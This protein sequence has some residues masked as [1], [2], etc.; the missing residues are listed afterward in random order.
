MK[1]KKII[2][3][4]LVMLMLIPGTSAV[5]AADPPDLIITDMRLSKEDFRVGDVVSVHID[6]KNIGGTIMDLGYVAVEAYDGKT[7]VGWESLGDAYTWSR[8][9]IYPGQTITGV[10]NDIKI[11]GT[12]VK[13]RGRCNSA[14]NAAEPT[15][16]R[17]NNTY[18]AIFTPYKDKHDLVI[19]DVTVNQNDVEDGGAVIFEVEYQNKGVNEIDY[20]SIEVELEINSKTYLIS[21]ATN[22]EKSEIRKIKSE[23]LYVEGD[24]YSVKAYINPND[25]VAENNYSNNEFTKTIQSIKSKGNEYTWEPARL[26]GGGYVRSVYVSP[27]HKDH[28]FFLT[29]VNGAYRYNHYSNFNEPLI[30]THTHADFT[31]GEF[32]IRNA[33]GFE[34]DPQNSNTYFY[35][36]GSS[37]QG[38]EGVSRPSYLLRSFD[39]GK[40]W[41][42]IEKEFEYSTKLDYCNAVLEMDPNNSNILYSGSVKRGLFRSKNI[43]DRAPKWEKIE[44]PGYTYSKAGDTPIVG[45]VIDKRTVANGVSQNIYVAA[46][47]FGIYKSTDGGNS[48]ALMEG[49]PKDGL[50]NI[51]LDA[52]YD[53]LVSGTKGLYH[54]KNGTWN[55]ISPTKGKKYY[56]ATN[57]NDANTIVAVSDNYLYVTTDG[58]KSWREVLQNST[59]KNKMPWQRAHW[60]KSYPSNPRFDPFNN[61]RVV[62]GAWFGA[63]QTMDVTATNVV[64]EDITYGIDELFIR[65][66]ITLPEGANA[67]IIIGSNDVNGVK[68]DTAFDFP[69]TIIENPWVQESVGLDFCYKHPNFIARAGGYERG[70]G[71]GNGAYSIDGGSTWIEFPTYPLKQ[72]GTD[73]A[74]SGKI[75]VSSDYNENGVPTI[76]LN[77]LESSYDGTKLP[78]RV[79]RTEDLGQTWTYIDSLPDNSVKR[80]LHT[81]E[82][83]MADTVNKDVFYFYDADKGRF[84]LSTN[85]GKSFVEKN[86]SLPAGDF[87]TF[88]VPV[89]D[90]EGCLYVSI[91]YAGLYYSSDYGQSFTKVE[92]VEASE[93]FDLGKD[94]PCNPGVATMYVLGKVN[95]H[96]GMFR[97][98]D[99]GKTW[100]EISDFNEHSL[101]S[102]ISLIR[103][104]RREFG[105]IYVG[106]EGSGII[107]GYPEKLDLMVP[108]VGLYNNIDGKTINTSSLT[109]TGETTKPCDVY[110]DLNGTQSVITVGEDLKYSK[111]LSG[112]VSAGWTGKTNSLKIYAVDKNEQKSNEINVTFKY[113]KSYTGLSLAADVAGTTTDTYTVTGSMDTSVL[114]ASVYVDGEEVAVNKQTGIFS[115]EVALKG[116]ER[117]V[118]VTAV[119]KDGTEETLEMTIVKDSV[120]PIAT[121]NDLPTVATSPLVLANVSLDEP[122]VVTMGTTEYTVYDKNNLNLSIPFELNTGANVFELEVTD[123]LGNSRTQKVEI[124]FEA[125]DYYKELGKTDVIAYTATPK[126]DGEIEALWKLNRPV[127][128]ICQ[129]T[130]NASAKYGLLSDENYLYFAAEVYDKNVAKGTTEVATSYMV[131]TLEICIDPDMSRSTKYGPDDQQIRLGIDQMV[132]SCTKAKAL[133][134]AITA[135]KIT[136]TGYIIEIAIPWEDL[137]VEYA[138]GA[139]FGFEMAIN[140][141]SNGSARDGVVCWAADDKSWTDT[142]KFGTAYIGKK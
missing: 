91:S 52:N 29:D 47:G 63:Y 68:V 51:W 79:Y 138:V 84:L 44:L 116:D 74:Q 53:L 118:E 48:F 97:S 49:S 20:T 64:W 41:T 60:Y 34:V 66:M 75:T 33:V 142:S 69:T 24:V 103:A 23:P 104:D 1:F 78:G 100:V 81:N 54:Y 39:A 55:D 88:V 27:D 140:D 73:R 7:K 134:N 36:G 4:M 136:D 89:P 111:E 122:G 9:K 59:L 119:L 141:S 76:L 57:P 108:R 117:V 110:I 132:Y 87:Y 106:T 90:K 19:N 139:K 42:A 135:S 127:T 105:V 17:N 85:G 94:A 2:S 126:I 46:R 31:D 121:F 115:K 98:T 71:A 18:S 11:T 114:P 30:T 102:S 125:D 82:P 86:T 14:S 95:G 28:V 128:R 131:D 37:V 25:N 120:A 113:N 65:D 77:T 16:N 107:V 72:N 15:G 8:P 70:V 45:T 92:G 13:I 124:V 62:Y 21:E 112:F 123:I 101:W 12:E 67:S 5:F 99:Q 50:Y 10:I 32:N 6:V 43:L 22:V 40:T 93:Y 96:D 130:P 58:G 61:N 109:I 35:A 133:V 3:L 26:G 129:S 137:A 83:L 56:C 80:F 38:N